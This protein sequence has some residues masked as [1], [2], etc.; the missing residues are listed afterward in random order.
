MKTKSLRLVVSILII[1]AASCDEPETVVTDIVHTDGSVTRKIE[2]KNTANK[3]ELSNV[4]V[5]YDST[6]IIR[7]SLEVTGE[8]TIWVKRA[9][10]LFRNTGEINND[11][12]RDSSANRDAR[13]KADFI[14][15]FKWF[16]TEY[17]FSEMAQ[18]NLKD[19]YPVSDFLD[20]DELA[21]FYSPE[22]VSEA[23]KNGPDSLKFRALNDTVEKKTDLWATR[24]LVSEW[25]FTFSRLTK[26][27]AAGDMTYDSLKNRENDFVEIIRKADDQKFDSLWRNGILLRKFIGE[28]NAS[29]YKAEADSAIAEVT[30]RFFLNFTDY[31][32][33][34]KMPGELIGTN[35]IIDSTGILS[36]NVKSDYF[37]TEDYVMWAESRTPNRWAWVLT[38][39]FLVFVLGGILFRV[40]RK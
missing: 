20:S 37:M 24:S 22:A 40:S 18:K 27:R 21:W 16:N 2:M 30:N 11:Y 3:F 33:R 26:E 12:L 13:R 15:K 29:K 19:G 36:W 17:R 9:E 10:K 35:G 8:D 25:I 5:P 31:I 6:W 14:R 1:M 32:Q 28:S 4:Q 7:D 23:K 39:I 38:G 34:I